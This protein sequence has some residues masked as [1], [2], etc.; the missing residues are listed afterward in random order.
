MSKQTKS[1]SNAKN[2]KPAKE[3]KSKQV[4][5]TNDF[6]SEDALGSGS[7]KYVKLEKG[8]KSIRFISKPINGW[9]E[10]I[11]KKPVRTPSSE[12]EPEA[13]DDENPPKKFIAAVV[14]DR[15]D[16]GVKI[17]EL[18]QQS[19]IKAIRALTNNP[20]WGNPFTYDISIEKSGEG[21]KTKYVV[22][23]EPKEPLSKELIEAANESP[24][25]LEALFEGEDPWKTDEHVTEYH[26]RDTGKR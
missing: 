16:D 23:P 14:I 20:K 17:L 26:F 18:T 4:E 6:I 11:D 2:A 21:M 24:C 22:T 5:E 8:T 1:A 13:S 15:D 10:W 7:A 9:L 25:N 12:G 19:V 3:T